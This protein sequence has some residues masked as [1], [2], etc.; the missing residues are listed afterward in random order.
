MRDKA[1]MQDG[2][3]GG[4]EGK[5][6]RE[7]E[8]LLLVV[9]ERQIWLGEKFDSVHLIKATVKGVTSD[10]G[11]SLTEAIWKGAPTRPVRVCQISLKSMKTG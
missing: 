3:V 4:W 5:W 10:R 1:R 9:L 11:L 7:A 8:T 6:T 2:W